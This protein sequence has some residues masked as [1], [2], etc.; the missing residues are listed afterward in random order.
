MKELNNI[1]V[2]VISM[3][4]DIE[5]RKQISLLF[6][7]YNLKYSF[8]DAVNGKNLLAKDYYPLTK[9][10]NFLFNRRYIIS[11]S[12]VGCRLSHRNAIIDFISNTNQEWLLIF[13]DDITFNDSLVYFLSNVDGLV[14]DDSIIIHLGGQNGLPSSRRLVLRKDHMFKALKIKFVFPLCLRWLYRTCGYII[15]RSAAKELIKAHNGTFVADDWSY[16]LKST[17]INKVY[18]INLITHPTDLSNSTIE[19]ERI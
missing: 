2:S 14:F 19:N 17:S 11:P 15:N 1:K 6:E 7:K 8:I 5:R 12:E 9:N 4:S 18:F 16:I 10:P 3:K 13:E